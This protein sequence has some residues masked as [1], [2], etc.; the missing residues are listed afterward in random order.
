MDR[1]DLEL[2]LERYR[3][4]IVG[5]LWDQWQALGVRGYSKAS[6]PVDW[7]ID[8]ESLILAS[9]NLFGFEPRLRDMVLSWIQLN[10]GLVSIDRLKRLQTEHAIGEPAALW[11]MASILVRSGSRLKSWGS[12]ANKLAG[13]AFSAAESVPV[14]RDDLVVKFRPFDDPCLILKVRSLLGVTSRVEILLWLNYHGP[15]IVS[16]ISQGTGWYGKTVQ[17]TL[18]EMALSGHVIEDRSGPLRCFYIK[19]R[20]WASFFPPRDA[21]E[22][23]VGQHFLYQGVFGLLR[24]ME[25]VTKE[26]SGA[27]AARI[28]MI[29]ELRRCYLRFQK[30]RGFLVQEYP[31]TSRLIDVIENFVRNTENGDAWP[32]GAFVLDPHHHQLD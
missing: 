13:S 6:N 24:M 19:P 21:N 22:F 23:W 28:L 5:R 8:P 2:L 20:D 27:A 3:T 25:R 15:S 9:S 30:A 32:A 7:V 1:T 31:S 10:N 4:A 12:I 17:N 11:E 26:V 16:H 18:G 14:R 29:E